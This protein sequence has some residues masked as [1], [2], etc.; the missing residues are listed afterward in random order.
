[1]ITIAIF[2]GGV[3]LL[4]PLVCVCAGLGM[5]ASGAAE[6]SAS[7]RVANRFRLRLDLALC[8]MFVCGLIANAVTYAGGDPGAGST[9]DVVL[10]ALP[11]GVLLPF[12]QVRCASRAPAL[13]R[14]CCVVGRAAS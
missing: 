13:G 14:A 12:L 2:L 4:L 6:P 3:P 11:A 9:T 8:W 5:L 10:T 1:M 7:S